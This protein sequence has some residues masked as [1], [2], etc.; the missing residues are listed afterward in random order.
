MD[1]I[2]RSQSY[3]H[4]MMKHGY[5]SVPSHLVQNMDV[6]KSMQTTLSQPF[7]HDEHGENNQLN[8]THR[9]K[10]MSRT[11]SRPD[12]LYQGSLHNIPHYRSHGDLSVGMDKYGSIR[13][14]NES[15][16]RI[17]NCGIHTEEGA[18]PPNSIGMLAL[19]YFIMQAFL[20]SV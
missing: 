20:Y 12:I 18:I 19:W 3:G 7:L 5:T 17:D 6:P 16:V 11:F 9:Q 4:G 15:E 2:T 14:V 10:G 1:A 13:H 8:H